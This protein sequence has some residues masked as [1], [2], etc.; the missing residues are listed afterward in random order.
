[1]LIV[2]C[3][4]LDCVFVGF[5]ICFDYGSSLGSIVCALLVFC[6]EFCCLFVDLMLV[7]LIVFLFCLCFGLVCGFFPMFFDYLLFDCCVRC[8]FVLCSLEF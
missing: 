6:W 1:M 8:F 4:L 2:A 3:S 7:C 5:F